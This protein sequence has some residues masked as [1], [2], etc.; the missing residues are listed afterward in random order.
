MNLT[1]EYDSLKEILFTVDPLSSG[2]AL[3]S[4]LR[5]TVTAFQTL[6]VP[7]SVQDLQDEPVHDVL[8]TAS[9]HWHV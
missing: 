8:I 7:V 2:E 9:T 3:L 1:Y 4:K 5:L 6:A